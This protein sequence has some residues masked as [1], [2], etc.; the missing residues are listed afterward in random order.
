MWKST[1]KVVNDE[2][3]LKEI[4]TYFKKQFNMEYMEVLNATIEN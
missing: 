3:N 1:L 2:K 4:M